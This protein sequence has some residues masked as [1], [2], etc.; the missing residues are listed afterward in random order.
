MNINAHW[1]AYC[2]YNN[3]LKLLIARNFW[4]DKPESGVLLGTNSLLRDHLF[5]R[6]IL[7]GHLLCAGQ[8][9]S[10]ERAVSRMGW[11][12]VLLELEPPRNNN[13]FLL[14]SHLQHLTHL[15]TKGLLSY[16]IGSLLQAHKKERLHQTN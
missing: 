1:V 3:M 9:V 16:A 4:V 12:P 6:Q 2:E 13:P 5:T 11:I 15:K 10:E 14:L 7:S 8:C